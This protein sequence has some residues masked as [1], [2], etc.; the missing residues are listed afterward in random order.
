MMRHLALPLSLALVV[1]IGL[2]RPGGL[3]RKIACW[4]TR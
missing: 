2:S 3:E 1:S 4:I